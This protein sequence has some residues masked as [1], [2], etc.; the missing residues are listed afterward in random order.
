MAIQPVDKQRV[1]RVVLAL[2]D[3]D[4]DRAADVVAEAEEDDRLHEYAEA[5]LGAFLGF[6]RLKVGLEGTRQWASDWVLH[7]RLEEQ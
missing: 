3:G 5:I 6:M 1:G 4:S 7:A 2:L